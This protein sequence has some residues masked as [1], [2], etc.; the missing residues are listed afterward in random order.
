MRRADR[1][2]TDQSELEALLKQ[3]TV[4]NLGLWD[5][6][7]VYV[8]PLNYGYRDRAIYLHSALEGRKIDILR[9]N[10]QVCFSITLNQ[11]IVESETPCNWGTSFCSLIGH[12]Q[13]LFLETAEEKTVGLDAFMAQF[14]DRPQE[15]EEKMLEVTAVI[16][17]DITELTGKRR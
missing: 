8:V 2:I 9:R 10:P 16:R 11:E 3:G 1:E 17:I 14:T 4:V 7:Q 13:A 15:Y 6:E 5:G 12:G